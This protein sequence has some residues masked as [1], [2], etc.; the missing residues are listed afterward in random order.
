VVSV[1]GFSGAGKTRLIAQLIPVLRSLGL[2]VGTI[3]HHRHSFDMDT[4]GKDSW[5]HRKAGAAGT[6]LSS[7]TAIGL[8]RNVEHDHDPHE[9]ALL[10]PD[11]DLIVAEGYKNAAIPKVEVFRAA[12]SERPCCTGDPQLIA[13]VSDGPVGWA[14]PVFSP[15]DIPGIAAFLVSHF[16]L[17]RDLQAQSRPL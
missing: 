5:V 7:P 16:R 4:P 9:L 15:E 10:L 17:E 11:V 14:G 13:L 6:V 3:K 8:I 12:V 1:A 2:S